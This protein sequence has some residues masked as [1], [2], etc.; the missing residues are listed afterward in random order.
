VARSRFFPPDNVTH[1]EWTYLLQRFGEREAKERRARVR[2][3]LKRLVKNGKSAKAIHEG[4]MRGIRLWPGASVT[5]AE[6]RR[7]NAKIARVRKDVARALAG[8]RS[9]V[10]TEA[11]V[12]SLGGLSFSTTTIRLP[13]LDDDEL[14]A[15]RDVWLRPVTRPMR[16]RGRP[17]APWTH[18]ADGALKEAKIGNADRRELLAAFG[19][20]R[21]D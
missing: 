12:A 15:M 1:G 10:P 16:R 7:Y 13:H 8:L 9:L 18:A 11:T 5:A 17:T 4:M 14:F 2:A 19:F 21:E 20:V 6:A 3:T